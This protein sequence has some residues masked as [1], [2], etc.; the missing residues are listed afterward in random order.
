MRTLLFAADR[1]VPGIVETLG[2]AFA[3]DE[4]RWR[5][6]DDARDVGSN[7]SVRYRLAQRFGVGVMR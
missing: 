4:S 2:F 5:V 6:F 1:L 7:V 3:A